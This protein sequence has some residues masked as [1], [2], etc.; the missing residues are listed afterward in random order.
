MTSFD[1][2]IKIE[3][4]L[5][6]PS[7]LN[8]KNV[9]A[10]LSTTLGAVF[11]AGNVIPIEAILGSEDFAFYSRKVPSMFY[12]LGAKDTV[13]PC[14]FLHDSKV[15]FNEACIPYGSKLLSEGALALLK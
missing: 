12:F 9:H 3:Y 5:N 6:Y 15:I 7:L 11:G 10:G 13:E 4:N 2:D 8:D 14:Y 1:A